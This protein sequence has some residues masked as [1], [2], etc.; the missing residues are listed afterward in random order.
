MA[1]ARDPRD[2]YEILGVH[3]DATQDE[4]KKAY[5]RLA[6]QLH[7]D[8]NSSEEA[9]RRFKE[10]TGAYEILSDSG[11]RRQYDAYGQGGPMGAPFADIQ[12]IFDMFFGGSPFGTTFGTRT[13]TR[14]VRRSRARRGEDLFA[15]VALTFEEAAFGARRE[16]K[17][18]KLEACG[19]CGGE[20]AAPG[21]GPSRC[22]TCG[23]SGQVQQV[24]DSI[25]GTVMTSMPCTICGGSGEELRSPCQTCRGTGQ[26]SATRTSPADLP[27]GVSDGLEL[28]IA[29][30]GHAGR[31]GGPPG[32]LFLRLQVEPHPVFERRGQDL[33]AVL[34]VPMV[35]AALGTEIEIETLDGTE[36]VEIEPGTRSGTTLRLRGKGV[37][38][39]NRRGRGDLFLSI[40]VDILSGLKRDERE[41]LQQLAELRNERGPRLRRPEG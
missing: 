30:A 26:V 41:L 19:T 16:L 22:R 18:E 3:H 17:I 33:F 31:A 23:G 6:R 24:R 13:R 14:G 40:D 27:P 7:P 25:F 12:E 35:Q 10:V 5:R 32:D 37:P 28:R 15:T 39:L 4:I 21:T 11:R 38:N 34:E 29:G 36:R 2:L 8:V 1:R 20:G 9:E